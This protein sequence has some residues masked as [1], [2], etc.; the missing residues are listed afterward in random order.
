[1]RPG[2]PVLS[3]RLAR[4]TVG[5]QMSNMGLRPC[6]TPGPGGGDRRVGEVREVKKACQM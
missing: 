2:W 3:M 4:L 5:P 6:S 1:M